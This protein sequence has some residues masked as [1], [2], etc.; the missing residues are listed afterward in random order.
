MATVHVGHSTLLSLST[1]SSIEARAKEVGSGKRPALAEKLV[2][3]SNDISRM[4]VSLGVEYPERVSLIRQT[5]KITRSAEKFR[6]SLL[7]REPGAI[8]TVCAERLEH[9]IPPLRAI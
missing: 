3:M 1:L 8:G 4:A 6:L 2:A 5:L 7:G 9:L